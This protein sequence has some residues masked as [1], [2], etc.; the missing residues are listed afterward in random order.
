MKSTPHNP[1]SFSLFPAVKDT[2]KKSNKFL[3]IAN[4][5]DGVK[6]KIIPERAVVSFLPVS[7]LWMIGFLLIFSRSFILRQTATARWTKF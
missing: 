3:S 6:G 7:V 4:Q 2:T 1:F 5:F